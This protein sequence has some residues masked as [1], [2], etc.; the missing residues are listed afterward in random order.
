MA[1]Q[2]K[3]IDISI[4]KVGMKKDAHGSQLSEQEY[5][6]LLNGNIED[7]NGGQLN[8]TNEHSNVLS[9]KFKAGFQVHGFENDILSNSTYFFLL[10][11]TTGVGELGRIENNQEVNNLE[12]LTVDCNDCEQ[13]KELALPLEEITQ[14]PLQQYQTLITDA[15]KPSPAEGFNF[16][17]L[18]PIKT[19]VIKNEKSGKIIYFTELNNFPR[20]INLSNI[21]NYYIQNVPCDDDVP[22]ECPDFD[23][24]RIF[25]LYDI[26]TIS[27]ASIELGGRL[28]MGT[29]EFLIAYS[30]ING[31]EISPYYSVTQPVT[32]FDKNNVVLEQQELSDRTNFAIKLNIE[33]L[34]QKYAYYK[35]AVIQTADIEGATRYFIEGV[36]NIN[37]TTVVYSTE[38]NK[39]TTS[40]DKLLIDKLHIEKTEGLRASNNMLMQW[41]ITQKKE[42]NLQPVVNLIGQFIRWQ[43]SVANEN[44]YEDGV[45]RSKFLGYPRDEIVPLGIRFFEEGGFETAIFPFIARQATPEDSEEVVKEEA[46]EILAKEGET[47]N[48]VTS[49]LANLNSCNTTGRTKKWQ[50]YNTAKEEDSA[51]CQGESLET[52]EVIERVEKVCTI[53][54]IRDTGS[55]S[56]TIEADDEDYTTF[57]DYLRDN[58]QNCPNE[59]EGTDI[60]EVFSADYSAVE[61]NQDIFEGL[62]YE[63]IT[64]TPSIEVGSINGLV[65]EKVEKTFP[66]YVNI[67]P[68]S[69]CSLYKTEVIADEPY[70]RPLQDPNNQLGIGVNLFVRDSD[71]R[72]ESCSYAKD[73]PL[74]E[75]LSPNLNLPNFNNYYFSTIKAS[76][77]TSKT[78]TIFNSDFDEKIHKGGLW[79]SGSTENKNSFILEV[80]ALN[81]V[82]LKD[83]L[84]T[85]TQA[86]LSIFSSCSSTSAVYSVLYNVSEGILLKLEKDSSVATTLKITDST[87]TV[88]LPDSW[89]TSKKYFVVIDNPLQTITVDGVNKYAVVPPS[90]CYTVTKR[91]IEFSSIK[92]SWE[93]ITLDKKITFI[94]DVTFNQPVVKN[95]TAV[96]FKKGIFG[97]HE[98]TEI[99]PDNNELYNSSKLSVPRNLIPTNIRQDFENNFVKA[100]ASN[101]YILNDKTNFT[102]QPIRHFRF[103]DNKTAPF[104]SEG[105]NTLPFGNALIY[106]LGIT[107]DENV[108][109][110]F[111]DVAVY[112][113]LITQEQRNRLTKYEILRGDMTLER[114]IV[115]SGLLYDMRKYKENNKTVYY[116]NYPYNTYSNDVLNLAEDLTIDEKGAKF[117]D[118]NRQYT[119]HSPDTDYYRPTLPSELS[120][121]GY[122][123]GNSK[124]HF[125][126]VKQ[127]PRWVILSP[128]ARNLASTL[129]TL[130]VVLEQLV[131]AASSAEVF[132]FGAGLAFSANPIGIGF[133]AAAR[134][135]GAVGAAVFKYGQYRYQWLKIFKDLGTPNNFAYYYFSEGNYNSLSNL[136]TI[137]D[138]LRGINTSKYLKD[139]RYTVVNEVTS[140]K[141]NV[142]NIDREESVYVSIGDNKLNYPEV[143][144]N[145]DK[146]TADSSLTYS[147]LA[148]LSEAGRSSEIVR[149]IASPYVALKNYLPAQYGRINSIKWLTTS[150]IGDLTSP[151]SSCLSIFGG[152][153]YISRHTLKRKIPLFLTT[154]MK[155]ADLTPFNYFY[156][157]NIGRNPKFYVSYEIDKDFETNGKIFPDIT[158]D[159]SF[160]NLTSSTNYYTPPSKFYLYY[161]GVPSFLAE[162]RINT[163]YRYSGKEPKDSF[164]P[165]VGDLG[166]WTQETNIPI[167]ER[168]VFK[169]NTAYSKQVTTNRYRTLQNDYNKKVYDT[170]FDMPNGIITSLADNNEDSLY[171][172]WLIYRPLD[173]FQFPS[174]YGKLKDIIDT[175][176]QSILAR[177]EDTSVLYNKVDSKMDT[178]QAPTSSL[179]GGNSLFIR[180]PTTFQNTNIGFGGTQSSAYISNEFGHFWPDAKRGQMIHVQTNGEGMNEISSVIDGKPSGM[181]NWFKEHLPFKILK[182]I[183]NVDIDNPLS[184]VGIT[185]GWDSR[186]RR[187]FITK[188]DIVPLNH[189]IKWDD[190]IGFYVDETDCNE[191]Q[192][193]IS[194]PDGFTYNEVTQKCERTYETLKL[195]PEGFTYDVANKKCVKQETIPVTCVCT[196]D[197]IPTYN[198][199]NVSLSTKTIYIKQGDTID[200]TFGTTSTDTVIYSYTAEASGVTGVSNGTGNINQTPVGVGSVKYT[201]TP[202]EQESGC[203]GQSITITVII[204]CSSPDV[205]Y[206]II[207]FEPFTFTPII[208]ADLNTI[209]NSNIINLVTGMASPISI[210][211]G[212]YRVNGGSWV[213]TPSTVNNG[214]TVQVRRFSSSL[215][216][217]LVYARLTVGTYSADFNITTKVNTEP[218]PFTFTPVTN[219]ELSS[220]YDSNIVTLVI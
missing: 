75:E 109:N 49:I 29:Y 14:Q 68:V 90:G 170:L 2:G 46:G 107:I 31:N 55:G 182:S 209:Y 183:K 193:V 219:A 100:V 52:V 8:L 140:E 156:Y 58:F 33:G 199:E 105:I 190:E 174:N 15:C 85:T 204:E 152:D 11:P 22:L 151:Q 50:Y 78:S 76:L 153:T 191:E 177:F 88:S 24:M 186:Y 25:K 103:P 122:M 175:E 165:Y 218:Q 129:A 134:I 185:M 212:E 163:N 164:Y 119:F 92:V 84:P 131:V 81:E 70:T 154:A 56:I 17:K 60:C 162:S 208:D 146:N 10:N 115:A 83:G 205:I 6:H 54:G 166:E 142:N 158:T 65:E 93:S 155:Q 145:F 116:S 181:R 57:E 82:A 34:D 72:N 147:S 53:Q 20:Y 135:A 13:I 113:K 21:E 98:S 198:N 132:R 187:I 74:M 159:F 51:I 110:A 5:T 207:T 28:K 94:A 173:V 124:G 141:V 138:T 89:F 128:K 202:Q 178:G 118:S 123:F 133:F 206:Q 87:G 121:Q 203:I 37:D 80:S 38:Q 169:Y 106:P 139:G 161:Y 189:C 26:P 16:N 95:C 64:E 23:S 104:I 4:A 148:G 96:P 210:L 27:T 108:I 41:G 136:Q 149:N 117:G 19:I 184:G 127:H 30:D 200:V 216:N 201:I 47:Y 176:S 130:E 102:C 69:E 143:Y 125:D 192:A 167:R 112:N 168:N 99:Y 43:T 79:Y 9:S 7:Q 179:L 61:C 3:K 150:Y 144:K 220:N 160:D 101:N 86:R 214:D 42:I 217:T 126:E 40:I 1:K 91:E 157:S 32:V 36:H 188:K 97:Y 44:L 77:L 171:D 66:E 172:P 39:V 12:D 59:F 215:Y 48:D 197:V 195:C 63:I 111:L 114:S 18:K 196:A 137:G 211:N 71:F 62:D 67:T 180:R 35:I 213:S 45:A 73:I 194:C 120:I